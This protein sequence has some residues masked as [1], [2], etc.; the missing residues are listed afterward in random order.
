MMSKEQYAAEIKNSGFCCDHEKRKKLPEKQEA[1]SSYNNIIPYNGAD[2]KYNF[3]ENFKDSGYTSR[4]NC[5]YEVSV[6][7]KNKTEKLICNFVA[8]IDEE[9]TVDDGLETRKIFKIEGKHQ[10]G[11]SLPKI[12][13][14]ENDF[15]SMNWIIKKW[16]AKCILETGQAVK[17][18]LRHCIQKISK[19]IKSKT[20]FSFTG[21]KKYN[22]KW[23]Y[24]YSGGAV[25]ADNTDVVLEGR[26]AKFKLPEFS[27]TNSEEIQ[28][29]LLEFMEL[30]PKK[31][32]LPLLAF[33]FLTPL[34]EFLKRA[35][36]E[37]NFV[38]YLLGK[39]GSGKSTLSALFL[40]FF[41]QF[42]GTELPLSFM[43]TANSIVSKAFAMKDFLICID[44]YKP[45]SRSDSQRMDNTA[46]NLVR[47]YG[48]R[49]GRQRLKSDSSDMKQKY[50][51]GNAIL[52]GEQ[53]PNISESGTAR[54]IVA[55]IK[56]GEINFDIMTELQEK[57]RNNIYNGI[58][59]CY[60]EYIQ[61]TF[62]NEEENEKL[63]I[64]ILRKDFENMRD[65]FHRNL[66]FSV[67]PRIP[68]MLAFLKT[69]FKYLLEFGKFSKEERD[70][71]TK[72]LDGILT[73]L[74][75]EHSEI[76]VTDKPTVKF[77]NTLKDIIASG[78]V[79][80][81]QIDVFPNQDEENKLLIGY[82][83][84]NYYY[85]IPS[86]AYNQVCVFYS[87]QGENFPTSLNALLKQL[88]EEG[89]IKSEGRRNTLIKRINH[90]LRGRY[91][92]F[93][94]DKFDN[95]GSKSENEVTEV[96]DITSADD[97]PF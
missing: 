9:V 70:L 51:R 90:K 29:M 25:G 4:D 80:V 62:L 91:I 77:I 81:P 78:T 54:M 11:Y 71:F 85:F 74:A 55:E 60:I 64:E 16:G 1:Q 37:P 28:K 53:M 17:D 21:W 49:T 30:A 52:T 13:V 24:L 66:N 35:G 50:P 63:F 5:I 61:N 41:G 43:D 84:D 7:D 86:V 82:H 79:R 68:S 33:V 59:R 58:M 45:S 14:S 92:Y 2:F 3:E 83:D 31:V 69:G 44:D 32:I 48:E 18:K 39:T 76:S 8:L 96:M 12:D 40:S 26:L 87:R 65:N 89:F 19:D 93:H 47:S 38:Y 10:K 23:I 94:K 88:A 95:F 72:E 42:S 15:A 46:Q 36:Y 6:R 57:A 27:I 97:L 73:D 20:I 75:K 56:S 67:H 34:N 22:G